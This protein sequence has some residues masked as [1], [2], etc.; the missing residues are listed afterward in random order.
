MTSGCK[1]IKVK[2]RGYGEIKFSEQIRSIINIVDEFIADNSLDT[3]GIKRTHGFQSYRVPHQLVHDRGDGILS[4]VSI[5]SIRT[6]PFTGFLQ[7]G[8]HP[9]AFQGL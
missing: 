6:G 1:N 3:I 2:C 9:I 7:R 4:K 5:V 8:L